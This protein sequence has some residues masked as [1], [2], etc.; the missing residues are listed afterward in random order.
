MEGMKKPRVIT[1]AGVSGAGKTAVTKELQKKLP[2]A[3]AIFFDEYDLEGPEDMMGWLHRG[4]NYEE[5]DLTPL[6][7]DIEKLLNEPL[8]FI[9]MDFPFSYIHKQV[10]DYIDISVFIDTPLDI[11]MARR[12]IRDY[13]EDTAEDIIDSLKQY[14]A[15]GRK[16]YLEM[17][18]TVKPSGDLMIDGSLPAAEI[19]KTIAENI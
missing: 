6:V 1:I 13:Q 5:W 2:N 11:A 17:L 3:K 14:N 9:V 19:V 7:K 15:Q 18:R 10:K 12:I 16:A 8:D 4:S